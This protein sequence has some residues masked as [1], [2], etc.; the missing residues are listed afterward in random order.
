M[1]PLR[2]NQNCS[3]SS[4]M[5][6]LV[7]VGGSRPETQQMARRNQITEKNK[8][9]VKDINCTQSRIENKHCDSTKQ[10]GKDKKS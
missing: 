9:E 2:K 3:W 1:P 10:S 5:P 7:S 4:Y 8:S 6:P